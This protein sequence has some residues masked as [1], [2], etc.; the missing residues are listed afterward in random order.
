MI[1]S[2]PAAKLADESAIC[3]KLIHNEK[4]KDTLNKNV[5]FPRLLC[6]LWSECG[7]TLISDSHRVRSSYHLQY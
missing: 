5:T 4:Y 7:N 3:A 2:N 6:Q 1:K